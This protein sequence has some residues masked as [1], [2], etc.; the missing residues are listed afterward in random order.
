MI[1]VLAAPSVSLCRESE[2]HED[3]VQDTSNLCSTHPSLCP[4]KV[5]PKVT[6]GKRAS[7]AMLGIRDR[8]ITKLG[9]QTKIQ[10]ILS[11]YCYTITQN[12]I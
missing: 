11:D 12:R 10:R 8:S 7:R 3:E 5:L 4:S 1:A 9:K 2:Q 6:Q